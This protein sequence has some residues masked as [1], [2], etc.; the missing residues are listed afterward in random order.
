VRRAV[1]AAVTVLAG[2]AGAA[3]A[4]AA[5]DPPPSS[6]LTVSGRLTPLVIGFGDPVTARVRVLLDPA[7]VDA[8]S[9]RLRTD[10]A[11]WRE[12]RAVVR[13]EL[14]GLVEV[15]YILRLTCHAIPCVARER[16]WQYDFDDARL[17]YLEQGAERRRFVGWQPLEVSTRL[18]E[19][20]EPP[21]DGGAEAPPVWRASVQVPEPSFRASPRRLQAVLAAA[22]VLLIAGSLALGF[23]ILRRPGVP[24]EVPP[25]ER[26]L[27][28][29][30]RA[31]TAAERRAALEAVAAAVHPALAETAR[32]L[33]W[34]EEAP[35]EPAA[36]RLSERVREVAP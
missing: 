23:L 12:E 20:Y 30:A 14:E 33:A 10:F 5:A 3:D 25:L 16:Q 29:L 22:G 34:S 6:A 11:P 27:A 8:S 17:R 19:G 2:V 35:T 9:L 21:D 28:L 31:R 26:A 1:I 13:R 36:R 4:R 7:R 15:T 32:E 18:P 24:K